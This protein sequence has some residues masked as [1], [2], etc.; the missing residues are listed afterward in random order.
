M[1]EETGLTCDRLYSADICEQ[2]YE[3]DRDAISILPVFV[4]FVDPGAKV[5]INHEH[6]EFCWVPFEA[7]VGMVPFA[8]QRHVLRHVEAEFVQRAPVRHLLIGA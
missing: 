3:T 8:G 2:F 4:G 1:K 7:A 5:V 6:S